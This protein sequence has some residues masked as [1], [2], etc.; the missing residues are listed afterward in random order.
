MERKL[1]MDFMTVQKDLE[2]HFYVLI[3]MAT[4]FIVGIT[5]Y[6]IEFFK[7]GLPTDE[8]LEINESS[9]N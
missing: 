2:V 6:I 9:M 3:I 5:L 7:H 4:L 1:K 8:A